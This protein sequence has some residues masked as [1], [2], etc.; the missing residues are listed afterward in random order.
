MGKWTSKTQFLLKKE[1]RACLPTDSGLGKLDIQPRQKGF[2]TAI[3]KKYKP[4]QICTPYHNNTVA[5]R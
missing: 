5:D 1:N 4:S 3:R 2:I